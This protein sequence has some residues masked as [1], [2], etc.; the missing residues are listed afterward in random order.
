MLLYK[1][2]QKKKNLSIVIDKLEII[3]LPVSV[4]GIIRVH[5]IPI[6]KIQYYLIEQ[7]YRVKKDTDE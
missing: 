5:Y 4:Q 3:F 7:G 2:F 6:F 1:S